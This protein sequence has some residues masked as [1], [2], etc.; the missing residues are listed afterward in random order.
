[1]YSLLYSVQTRKM[2]FVSYASF[3]PDAS[4]FIVYYPWWWPGYP[5]LR[6]FNVWFKVVCVL[7]FYIFASTTSSGSDG[8]DDVLTEVCGSHVRETRV[9]PGTCWLVCHKP[10]TIV[11]SVITPITSLTI[12]KGVLYYSWWSDNDSCYTA[13]RVVREEFRQEKWMT[14]LEFQPQIILCTCT[15]G[16]NQNSSLCQQ[17]GGKQMLSEDFSNF[18]LK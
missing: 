5:Q 1:M 16:C 11:W 7:L 13:E 18:S 14:V 4:I 12:L 8:F 15:L 3:L 2:G 10:C 17:G 6:S 9:G